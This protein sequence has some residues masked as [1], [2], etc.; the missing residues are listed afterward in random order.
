MGSVEDTNPLKIRSVMP[1]LCPLSASQ[2]QFP[3]TMPPAED[4][5]TGGLHKRCSFGFHVSE[6]SRCRKRSMNS[7]DVLS[8]MIHVR[9][10]QSAM[11]LRSGQETG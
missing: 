5:G 8:S 6:Q 11:R 7:I 9:F 2:H 4:E 10:L 1:C 3:G